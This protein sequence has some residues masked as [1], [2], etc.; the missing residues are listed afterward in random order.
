VSPDLVDVDAMT[1]AVSANDDDLWMHEFDKRAPVAGTFPAA[2]SEDSGAYYW[3]RSAPSRRR[4]A[5]ALPQ[6][7][8]DLLCKPHGGTGTRVRNNLTHPG[9]GVNST[10]AKMRC[11]FISVASAV[12]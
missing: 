2:L 11:F 8:P 4:M 7:A 9:S 5:S 6:L 3:M 1:N 12:P 10:S